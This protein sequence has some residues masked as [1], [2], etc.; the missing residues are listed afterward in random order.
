M[1]PSTTTSSSTAWQVDRH[2][3]PTHL[4]RQQKL[5]HS[6]TRLS[7][8]L[9]HVQATR[10]YYSL[11]LL[12]GLTRRTFQQLR[13]SPSRRVCSSTHLRS[14]TTT[15]TTT[16]STRRHPTA[17]FNLA[18]QHRRPIAPPSS[19]RCMNSVRLFHHQKLHPCT[20]PPPTLA[21]ASIVRART[22]PPAAIR[23][24]SV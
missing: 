12:H 6:N 4:V 1:R 2:S 20:N 5:Q 16:P 23:S 15:T 3:S 21:S 8:A 22:P 10:R 7:F 11:A 24:S 9:L 18:S 14:S 19:H 17:P 13:W